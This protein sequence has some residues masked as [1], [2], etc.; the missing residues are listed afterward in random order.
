MMMS[1][2]VPAW[3]REKNILQTLYCLEKQDVFSTNHEIEFI[4]V[5]DC[6]SDATG[7]YMDLAELPNKKVIHRQSREKWNASIPRNIAAKESN[8]ESQLLYFLDSDVLLPPDR[9]RRIIEVW[10]EDNDRDQNRVIIGQYHYM[11]NWIDAKHNP[12]WYE[13]EIKNYDGDIRSQSF[14]DHP[15]QQKNKGLGFALAC[16]GGSLAIPRKLFFKAGGFDET[17]LSGVEDGDFGLTLWETG[18][19]FSLDS[20][21]LGWHNPH[22]IHPQRTMYIKECVDRLNAKHHMDIVQA[23]G[24]VHRQWGIG[25]WQ[26]PESWLKEGGYTKEEVLS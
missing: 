11:R 17:M 9:L 24:E 19:V 18:A 12:T 5:D 6:S 3:N 8:K 26:P 1:V 10:T 7:G 4:L 23:T 14:I 16:F 21:M 20:G 22:E 25:E 15:Y 13:R 2:I